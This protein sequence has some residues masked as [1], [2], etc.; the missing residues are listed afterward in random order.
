MIEKILK[1]LSRKEMQLAF[2]VLM[3]A[4]FGAP[5]GWAEVGFS[6]GS[7]PIMFG[8]SG[9]FSGVGTVFNRN[10][11][12]IAEVNS[13]DGPNKSR[14][15]I[16]VTSLDSTGGYKEFIPGFRDGGEIALDMNFTL[17]GYDDMNADF[18]SETI[19]TYSIVLGDTGN[20]TFSFSGYVTSLGLAVPLEDKVTSKVTI[21]ISGQVTLA[22]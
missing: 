3:F 7:I 4:V 1:M 12:A 6:I 8:V 16:D 15:T 21:K 9:A 13:I 2:V 5:S 17:D 19:Q 18:E 10:A 20:T 22:T 14:N 11:V